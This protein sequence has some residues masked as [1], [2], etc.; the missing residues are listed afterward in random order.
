ML[1]SKIKDQHKTF[2]FK[3]YMFYF[4]C[5]WNENGTSEADMTTRIH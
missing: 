2:S 1:E 3:I 5:T 4:Q